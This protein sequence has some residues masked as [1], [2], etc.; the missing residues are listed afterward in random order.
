MNALR[1]W[2]AID[3]SGGCVVRLL[4]GEAA[5]ETRYETDP[6]EVAR[7]FEAEGCDG[8]HVVD[9][10]AAFGR[11]R[12]TGVIESILRAAPGVPVQVGG[13][14]RT[15][16]GIESLLGAGASRVVVGSLPFLDPELFAELMADFKGRLVVAL[17]CK[18]GRPTVKGW[19]EDSG[20]GRV[21][22]VA[23][24]LSENGVEALLVTDV[25]CDGAMTGPNLSLLRDVR[26]A[27]RGE[28]LASGGVRG[29]E[30]LA[31]LDAALEG[32]PRGVILGRALHD[33]KTSV[34]RLREFLTNHVGVSRSPHTPPG[35]NRLTGAGR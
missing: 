1:L 23:S 29:E 15:R 27:F 13:G 5:A 12:N 24:R 22:D 3:L 26:S 35:M 25:A 21:E 19:T 18:E 10:D 9:L 11:G 14:V 20:A 34:A 2:P 17:D 28:I 30:D 7:R 6:Q 4:R 16:T 8:I 33:G 32:G 31:S